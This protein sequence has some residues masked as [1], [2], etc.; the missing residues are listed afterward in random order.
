MV[1]YKLV[2]FIKMERGKIEVVR[3]QKRTRFSCILLGLYK[4]ICEG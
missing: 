4:A 3:G 1:I 2:L